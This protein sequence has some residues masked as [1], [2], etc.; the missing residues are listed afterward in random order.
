LVVDAISLAL[1]LPSAG[2]S[3]V[4]LAGLLSGA[5]FMVAT[6]VLS[7]GTATADQYEGAFMLG[8]AFGS[9]I[10]G[11]YGRFRVAGE[12][13]SAIRKA[14]LPETGLGGAGAE[15]RYPALRGTWSSADELQSRALAE[16]GGFIGQ[17]PKER[18]IASE[19]RVDELRFESPQKFYS[20]SENHALALGIP[21]RGEVQAQNYLASAKG[22]IS[23]GLRR[24]NSGSWTIIFGSDAS[25]EDVTILF[26]LPR[27]VEGEPARILA[28]LNPETNFI[29]TFKLQV[30]SSGEWVSPLPLEAD[31]EPSGL[32]WLWGAEE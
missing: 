21:G 29:R 15:A 1:A 31:F 14:S 12:A 27:G 3:L 7:G 22:F 23:S 17:A 9:V 5:I 26:D 6:Y 25:P 16:E 19:G 32:A 11:V 4:F 10:G 18:W 13:A 2:T 24:G 20:H 28:A 8:F 30:F